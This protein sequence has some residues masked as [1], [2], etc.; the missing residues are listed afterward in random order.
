M[1]VKGGRCAKWRSNVGEM[2]RR[3]LT[4]PSILRAN[5]QKGA[6]E[7]QTTTYSNG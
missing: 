2:R 5:N 7:H 1:S 3:E 6:L 4:D